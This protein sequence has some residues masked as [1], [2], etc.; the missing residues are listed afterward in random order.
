M[1]SHVDAKHLMPMSGAAV[2]YGP[3][4]SHRGPEQL[5]MHTMSWRMDCFSGN[6]LVLFLL[7]CAWPAFLWSPLGTPQ[8][9]A[10]TQPSPPPTLAGGSSNAHED[11]RNQGLPRANT[12]QQAKDPFAG[13]LERLFEERELFVA[14][15]KHGSEFRSTQETMGQ[16]STPS[17]PYRKQVLPENLVSV[18][19]D[20]FSSNVQRALKQPQ[21]VVEHFHGTDPF[22]IKPLPSAQSKRSRD[23]FPER[24]VESSGSNMQSPAPEGGEVQPLPFPG[25]KRHI[26]MQRDE[27]F[28][29]LWMPDLLERRNSGNLL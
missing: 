14:A 26:S 23:P 20:T 17:V 10:A 9:V 21:M 15:G 8:T 7:I 11:Q 13:W 25:A 1:H 27:R 19:M 6:F 2:F 18:G 29:L 16:A 24:S 22:K 12:S 5:R 4:S 28:P 3:N